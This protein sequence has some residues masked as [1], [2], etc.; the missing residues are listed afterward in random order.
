M[1]FPVSFNF[2]FDIGHLNTHKFFPVSSS[3]LKETTN[4]IYEPFQ[5]IS[6]DSSQL[7]LS[8]EPKFIETGLCV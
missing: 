5:T 7:K 4:N 6:F 1:Q 8:N 2:T 3:S